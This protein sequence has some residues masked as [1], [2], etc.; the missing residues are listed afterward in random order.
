MAKFLN[1]ETVINMEQLCLYHGTDARIIEMTRDERQEY[2]NGCNLVI[3]ALYPLFKPLLEWEK[4]EGIINGEKVFF[5]E[6]PLKLR[7]EKLLNEKGGSGMY[8]NLFEKLTMIG[9]RNNGAGLYQYWDFYVCGSKRI[10]MNYAIRSNAGG[11]IGLNAYRLIQ[12]AEIIGFED[13]YQDSKVRLASERIKEFAKED[14]RRP[15]IVTIE[16][17]DLDYLFYEDGKPLFEDDKE[18]LFD[19]RKRSR[20]QFRY[21]KPVEL[22]LC[23]I[24]LLNKELCKKLQD[25][26]Y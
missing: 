26:Q 6:H 15:A 2:L 11:E 16:G 7:Y 8:L 1:C 14:N 12:G 5:Y 10:A 22:S 25:E 18:E 23:K 21:T 4:V 20:Y 19:R 3:D 24:D 17:I 13:M 9:A